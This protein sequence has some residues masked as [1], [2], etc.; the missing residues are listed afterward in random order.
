[1][2]DTAKPQPEQLQSGVRI[3]ATDTAEDPKIRLMKR[4][5]PCISD[6]QI[7]FD[8]ESPEPVLQHCLTKS[9]PGLPIWAVG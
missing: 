7:I 2:R 9:T 3:R 5:E 6:D 8:P 4:L 1:M